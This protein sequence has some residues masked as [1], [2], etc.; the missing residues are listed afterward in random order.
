[1]SSNWAILSEFPFLIINGTLSKV[2]TLV[3]FCMYFLITWNMQQTVTDD[4][5]WYDIRYSKYLFI[6]I[7]KW[8]VHML[9]S[10][11]PCHLIE[12]ENP[13]RNNCKW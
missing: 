10:Q 13:Y 6:D 11:G 5:L 3:S 4:T 8:I 12:E 1:M 7:Q 2:F 9:H